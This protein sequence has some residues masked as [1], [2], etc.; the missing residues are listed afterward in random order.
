M[1][2]DEMTLP[3]LILLAAHLVPPTAI[4]YKQPQLA[5]SKDL[6]A[7]VFGSG[8]SIYFTSSRDQGTTF[9]EPRKIADVPKLNLGNHRGPRVVFTPTAIV[10]SAIN[11]SDI[12]TWRSTDQGKTWISGPTINDVPTSADEGLQSMAAAPD[13]RIFVA[14]LD[15]RRTVPGKEL[16]G[17]YSTDNGAT[18]SKNVLV[19]HSPD[20]TICQCCHPTV[21]FTPTGQL[22]VMWR[23]ALG[24]SR[25]MYLISSTDG[26]K[27]FGTA[28]K[29]GGGTW[30]LDACP[31]DG[32][33][34]TITP[35][36]NV[37][38][39]WRRGTEI[40]MAPAGG[41]ETLLEEGKNSAIAS[42]KDGVYVAWSSPKG[43]LARVPGKTEPVTL[44][45]EG[46]FVQLIALPGGPILAAWERKGIIQFHTLP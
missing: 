19:Y 36:G 23:N 5:A 13:G 10:I 21:A 1:M 12:L 33:G 20:G 45:G 7:A 18:W 31:M 38:T 46:A 11:S 42:N 15:H 17:S 22:E 32:G 35:Q 39:S 2:P 28:E 30:K 34:L 9:S 24:G 8:T 4:D 25:D 44:D 6:V 29:L 37:I 26:G 41:A 27:T 43:I 16:Y 40:Y 14:W 3:L